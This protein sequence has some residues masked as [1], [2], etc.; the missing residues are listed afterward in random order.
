MKLIK[1]ELDEFNILY[2]LMKESFI[3]DE[4][5][6]VND[7]IAIF[8]DP[9]YSAHY[10]TYNGEKVGFI[11]LW[12]INEY[13]FIDHFA[14]FKEYRQ[15]GLGSKTLELLKEIYGKVILEIEYPENGYEEMK[16]L[17]F[18]LKNGFLINDYKYVLPPFR[19]NG[20]EIPLLVLSYPSKINDF[21]SLV[22]DIYKVAYN[23]I[24]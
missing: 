3:E 12:K 4:L 19:A 24:I 15:H 20:P 18:Y 2:N 5:R 21:D 22:K 16:R 1:I 10:I 9:L 11:C 6:E 13:I 7:A 8:N 14:I 23:K 17:S